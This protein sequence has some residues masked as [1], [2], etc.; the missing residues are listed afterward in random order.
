MLLVQIPWAQRIWA[1]PFFT[2]LAPS[3]RA[4]SLQEK[5]YHQTRKQQHKTL[6]DWARDLLCYA[7]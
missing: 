4:A 5:C 6:L 7:A 3:V 2:V 1:L